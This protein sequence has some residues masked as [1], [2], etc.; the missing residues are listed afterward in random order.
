MNP[1]RDYQN[2]LFVALF[3]ELEPFTHLYNALSDENLNNT[4][5]FRFISLEDVL[6][7]LFRKD[8]CFL[9]ED[10]FILL[11]EQ[12]YTIN[13]NMP[14]L[15]LDYIATLYNKLSGHERFFRNMLFKLPTPEVIVLYNGV[16]SF[17]DEKILK[18]SDAFKTPPKK[19]FGSIDLTVRVININNK[20]NYP[21][22]I[23]CKE[24]Y[25]YS[26]IIDKV[27][28]NWSL[29]SDLINSVDLALNYCIENNILVDFLKKNS[30][31]VRDMLL[32]EFEFYIIQQ[33]RTEE[34]MEKTYKKY[35]SQVKSL[36]EKGYTHEQIIDI[37]KKGK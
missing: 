7:R 19:Q 33:V 35:L 5:S 9:S 24:L 3:S 11:I 13:N 12:Q 34:G 29:G 20:R 2:S 32:R 17:P 23:K 22:L 26:I 8:V 18:L 30:L 6:F 21:I 1:D 27:R 4:S 31:D 15:L 16:D 36:S 28:E 37:L 25:E 10:R 14:L